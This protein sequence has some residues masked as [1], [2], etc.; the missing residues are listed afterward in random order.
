MKSIKE[1]I[2]EELNKL[3]VEAFKSSV[4]KD[5][6]E[7]AKELKKNNPH[8]FISIKAYNGDGK[9]NKE[10]ILA[11]IYLD[12]KNVK[13]RVSKPFILG[14]MTDEDIYKSKIFT[15]EECNKELHLSNPKEICQATAK[16]GAIS[17]ALSKEFNGQE[18][19]L[20]VLFIQPSMREKIN[21]MLEKD[22]LRKFSKQITDK[23]EKK[24]ETIN[25]SN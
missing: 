12:S 16:K 6:I 4:V 14:E 8:A 3:I 21:A 15:L 19:W 1:Y 18:E 2:Y 25:K 24:K 22:S 23:L 20:Y 10:I 11:Y 5:F 7:K 13:M 17:I 9:Y